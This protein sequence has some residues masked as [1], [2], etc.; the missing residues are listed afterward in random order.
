VTGDPLWNA[1]SEASKP[2]PGFA[3]RVLGRLPKASTGRLVPPVPAP[4]LRLQEALDRDRLRRRR[5]LR[6]WGTAAAAALLL[7]S[8][9]WAFGI[10]MRSKLP[11]AEVLAVARNPQMKP[12]PWLGFR[13]VVKGEKIPAGTPL[14]TREGD[15]LRL[16]FPDGSVADLGPGSRLTLAA[17]RAAF[18]ARGRV[19]VSAAKKEAPW[20]LETPEGRV[21]T[22][23]TIFSVT[24]DPEMPA[25]PGGDA[26]TSLAT[27][28]PRSAP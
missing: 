13:P 3:G 23:G 10:W 18:L 22:L 8:G 4:G 19:W 27:P 14:V 6:L 7:S 12:L 2:A 11:L 24:L 9:T 16:G 26:T 21:L 25:T 28:N 15:L 20:I 5:Y 1:A 17:P